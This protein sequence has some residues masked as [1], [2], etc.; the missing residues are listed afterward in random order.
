VA[1]PAQAPDSFFDVPFWSLTRA[2]SSLSARRRSRDRDAARA[3]DSGVM[4]DP[5]RE[6]PQAV[7]LARH[8]LD[9]ASAF[10]VAYG[11]TPEPHVIDHA[12]RLAQASLTLLAVVADQ[13]PRWVAER[14]F[15]NAFQDEH[16]Q[17][18][19]DELRQQAH[20]ELRA[21]S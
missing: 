19:L 11:T 16:W 14:L 8:E 6:L 9:R 4:K 3:I 12:E 2:N 18:R 10:T 7:E 17:A 15:K 1:V 21:G 5:E 20:D 13:T